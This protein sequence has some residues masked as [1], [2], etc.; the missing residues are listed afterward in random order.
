[1][2]FFRASVATRVFVLVAFA[3]LAAAGLALPT[4]I[5]FGAVDTLG[6]LW[7]HLALRADTQPA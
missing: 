2:P 1:V 5:L 6:G 3:G 4:L 7:T